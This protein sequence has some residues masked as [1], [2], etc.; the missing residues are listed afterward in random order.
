LRLRAAKQRHAS[1]GERRVANACVAPAAVASRMTASG[2]PGPC[3]S[4]L[5]VQNLPF[6]NLGVSS[7]PR[8]RW[9]SP[10][11]RSADRSSRSS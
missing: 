10:P 9:T 2:R 6:V 1:A 3:R 4:R 11:S 8:S 5:P 7:R